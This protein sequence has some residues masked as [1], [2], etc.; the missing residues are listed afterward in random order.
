MEDRITGYKLEHCRPLCVKAIQSWEKLKEQLDK[1]LSELDLGQHLKQKFETI[2]YHHIPKIC[3]AS[4]PNSCSQPQ[5]KD[6]AVIG[7]LRPKLT[8]EPCQ[9]CQACVNVCIEEAVSWTGQGINLNPELC[10]QCGACVRSC[11]SGT[12]AEE[13]SGWE[14]RLGGRV[15]RHP[16]FAQT[17]GRLSSDQKVVS[18]V[19][20]ILDYYLK[21]GNPEERLSHFLERAVL[22]NVPSAHESNGAKD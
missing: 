18:W 8:Q 11:P 22:S 1:A 3:I 17:V 16:R 12:L 5:I 6:F 2:L 19:I 14:L 15:G 13:D 9:G 10:V 20:E 21:Y 7:Y 4:C